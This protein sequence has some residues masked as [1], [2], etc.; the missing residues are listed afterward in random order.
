MV[1]YIKKY[2]RNLDYEDD[3]KYRM[4]VLTAAGLNEAVTDYVDRQNSN[5]IEEMLK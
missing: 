1:D 4:N 3:D 2:F 5:A